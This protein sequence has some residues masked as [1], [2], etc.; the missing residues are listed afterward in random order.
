M[1]SQKADDLL[2]TVFKD[3]V[4]A[5]EAAGDEV[6]VGGNVAFEDEVTSRLHDMLTNRDLRQRFRFLRRQFVI[7]SQP[8]SENA[9]HSTSVF[10]A[11]NGRNNCYY[12]IAV[13][14]STWT[15]FPM[16]S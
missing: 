9:G 13:S 3:L 11:I 6:D 12:P 16:K 2:A 15:P 5:R 1:R 4:S 14:R 7:S 8:L 10:H